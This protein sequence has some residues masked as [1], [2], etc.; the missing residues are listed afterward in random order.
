A[1]VIS[2]GCILPKLNGTTYDT[3]QSMPGFDSQAFANGQALLNGLVPLQNTPVAGHWTA[4]SPTA[5]NWRQEQI[6]VDQNI[7]DKTQVFVRWTQ[8]AWNT[9]AVPSLWAWASYDT[10]KTP[11]EGPGKS[12][13]LH[14]THSFKP[15][16]MNEF[17]A[18]YTVDHIALSNL[19]ADSVAKSINR[20]SNFLMNHLF[21]ANNSNPLLP[22]IELCGNTPYCVADDASNHPWFNSNPIIHWKN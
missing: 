18:A 6:R 22:A 2:D 10:I 13:V 11:F 4:A 14:I 12:G 17:I 21:S 20:P 8:D 9:V 5:T 3:V 15:N 19:A 7:S 16:L 1:Q